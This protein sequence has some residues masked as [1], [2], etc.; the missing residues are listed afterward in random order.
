MLKKMPF[1]LFG[2]NHE[3]YYN[4][5][6]LVELETAAGMSVLKLLRGMDITISFCVS[7]LQIGLKH[8]YPKATPLFFQLQIDKY[9]D[10]GGSLNGLAEPI[11]KAI[12]A[13]GIWGAEINA[14]V[15]CTDEAEPSEE[16]EKND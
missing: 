8:V 10:G 13:T 5:Q 11:V 6:R 16:T 3:I 15:N 2:E 12:A 4:T 7:A 14:Q 9:L 1:D